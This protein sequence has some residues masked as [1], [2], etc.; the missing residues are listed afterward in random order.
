MS[1]QS[2]QNED[3]KYVLIKK[4]GVIDAVEALYYQAISTTLK[5]KA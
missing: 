2:Y 5:L 3:Q 1:N 4:H